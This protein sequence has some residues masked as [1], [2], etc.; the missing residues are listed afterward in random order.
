MLPYQNLNGIIKVYQKKKRNEEEKRM[1]VVV[2]EKI[3]ITKKDLIIYISVATICVVSIIIAFYIQ[4]YG[5]IDIGMLVGLKEEQ[6]LGKK[7]EEEVATLKADFDKLFTNSL[8][9][10]GQ[11]D[12]KKIDS[13]KKL[14]FTGLEKKEQKLNSYNLEVRIPYIN[15]D[16]EI[17]SNYNKE[18][19]EKYV[20]KV[21]EILQSE[22]RNIRYSVEYAVSLQEDILSVLIRTTLKE[23]FDAQK[24]EIKTYNY[25][26]RNN[27][28]IVL[29][30]M[31]NF[32]QLDKNEIQTIIH[33]EIEAEQK[34][35][36]DLRKSGYNIY[37]RDITNNQYKIENTTEV[38]YTQNAIYIMYPY[39]NN[40]TTSELDMVII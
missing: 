34:K 36:E 28:E 12:N 33:N 37:N 32:K 6:H 25:D 1:K 38:Y 29:Q 3:K 30:D 35:V 11:H 19:E 8:D 13:N 2:P 16:N 14:V 4:F 7:T 40:S 10:S 24:T 15:I 9:D 17:V 21:Q 20:A 31:L 39:G 27:K 22:N 5:R 23:G 18:L 26:L